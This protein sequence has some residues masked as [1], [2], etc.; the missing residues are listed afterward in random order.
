[1]TTD[2][3]V[4]LVELLGKLLAPLGGTALLLA[5]IY[6][7]WRTGSGHLIRHRLWRFVHGKDAISDEVVRQFID[8]RTSLMAFRYG[9][10]FPARTLEQARHLAAWQR[11][12]HPFEHESGDDKWNS[13]G[14]TAAQGCP[15]RRAGVACDE[16]TT[17]AVGNPCSPGPILLQ[18][19][20][21]PV[22]YRNVWLVRMRD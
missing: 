17:D 15:R 1:M 19:H 4:G 2:A 22:Q 18:D 3:A 10:G 7:L 6:V 14:L 8:D 16:R 12:P 20:N 11:W 13:A 5:L 21:N 9:A